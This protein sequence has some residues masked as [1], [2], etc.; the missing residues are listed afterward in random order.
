METGFQVPSAIERPFPLSI[1]GVLSELGRDPFFASWIVL[2]KSGTVKIFLFCSSL[3]DTLVENWADC[4][5]MYRRN[6]SLLHLPMIIIFSGDTHVRY[7][8]IAAP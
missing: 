3:S 2:S 8:A 5:Q 7:I 6:V 1:Y 4:F